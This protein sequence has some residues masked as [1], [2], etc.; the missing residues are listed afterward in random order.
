MSCLKEKGK[1]KEEEERHRA[2][3]KRSALSLREGLS[4]T[5]GSLAD[6]H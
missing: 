4:S 2:D 5:F 3:E 6:R 1:K